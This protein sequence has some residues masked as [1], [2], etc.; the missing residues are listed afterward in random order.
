METSESG[1]CVYPRAELD[2]HVV[3]RRE[4]LATDTTEERE[5]H[6]SPGALL[7]TCIITTYSPYF[8]GIHIHVERLD[9]V[10]FFSC[11]ITIN[12]SMSCA[13]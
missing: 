9:S 1:R 11:M 8:L 2:I 5:R 6:V 7:R 10:L 13:H 4:H 3:R 12:T